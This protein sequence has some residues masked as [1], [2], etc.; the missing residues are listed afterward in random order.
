MDEQK[1]MRQ[2]ASDWYP[3]T[4]LEAS[5]HHIQPRSDQ[6]SAWLKLIQEKK[7]HSKRTNALSLHFTLIANQII[8]DEVIKGVRSDPMIW[9]TPVILDP[10]APYLFTLRDLV[11]PARP[12]FR[13]PKRILSE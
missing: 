3:L 12:Q 10:T 1:G 9:D 6:H 4:S 8:V 5:Q 11:K 13:T 2:D 7:P